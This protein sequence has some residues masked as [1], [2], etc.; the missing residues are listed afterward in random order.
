[1]LSAAMLTCLNFLVSSLFIYS[2]YR[3]SIHYID[4]IHN[5]CYYGISINKTQ[6]KDTDMT[7]KYKAV[8][9][10]ENQY[11]FNI[12]SQALEAATEPVRAPQEQVEQD[13]PTQYREP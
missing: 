13:V 5:V 3:D 4:N 1:Q 12:G 7:N 10:A 6:R 11:R 9:V 2:P 8:E